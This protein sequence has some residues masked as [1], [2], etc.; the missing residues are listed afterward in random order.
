MFII[1]ALG[2]FGP[3]GIVLSCAVCPPARPSRPRYYPTAH[4]IQG[5]LLI[6]GTAIDLSRSTNFNSYGFSVFICGI[7]WHNFM[8]TLTDLF[9]ELG[10]PRVAPPDAFFIFTMI[11][12]S[13]VIV[14]FI[15]NIYILSAKDFLWM[16]VRNLT[17]L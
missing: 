12:A 5:I 8:Y 7:Q 15:V 11:M 1:I 16:F 3:Y 10:P 17:A 13:I 4:N 14:I 6:F 9:T 2:P